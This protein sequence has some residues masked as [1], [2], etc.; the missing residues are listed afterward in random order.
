MLRKGVKGC[1]RGA[2]KAPKTKR[3]QD[4]S[5]RTRHKPAKETTLETRIGCS[6]DRWQRSVGASYNRI[7]QVKREVEMDDLE[8]D[9][10]AGRS[11]EPSELSPGAE[12]E[13]LSSRQ[14]PCGTMSNPYLPLEILMGSTH[15]KASFR[16]SQ[17][18]FRRGP[19]IMDEDLP[20]PFQFRSCVLYPHLGF[21]RH[22]DGPPGGRF[23]SNLFSRCTVEVGNPRESRRVGL[24]RPVP[25]TL[26]LPQVSP[27]VF[28]L[29]VLYANSQLRLFVPPSRRFNLVWS[30]SVIG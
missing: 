13:A 29:P 3:S 7:R 17:V 6:M 1:R 4:R 9:Q 10:S 30:R 12:T 2:A 11:G 5:R 14:K 23:D 8:E 27:C 28:S 16:Q 18:P 19:R 26:T 25:Q 15:P 20:G 24:S 22:D 21:S